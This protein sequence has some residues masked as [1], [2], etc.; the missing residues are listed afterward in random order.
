MSL[1]EILQSEPQPFA[2]QP[3]ERYIPSLHQYLHRCFR[4][5]NAENLLPTGVNGSLLYFNGTSWVTLAPPGSDGTYNLQI[6]K[7]GTT[8]TLS[9]A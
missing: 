8:F 4:K 2:I 9:W 5:I 7:S 1:A 3:I 6:V